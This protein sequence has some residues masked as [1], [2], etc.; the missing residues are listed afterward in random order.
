M[1]H[2]AIRTKNESASLTLKAFANF[3]PGL[4]FGNPGKT[5]PIL[6]DTNPERVAA[7]S[8]KNRRNSFRVTTKQTCILAQGFKANPGLELTNAFSVRSKLH[9]YPLLVLLYRLDRSCRFCR[10]LHRRLQ[11]RH[12]FCDAT[13]ELRIPPFDLRFR[14]VVDLDVWID[15]IA[16]NDPVAVLVG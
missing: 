8:P 15:S 1:R 4:R 5:R 7:R 14:I 12:H 16:F 10:Q 11:P 6:E 9:Q 13:F 3:S 2:E